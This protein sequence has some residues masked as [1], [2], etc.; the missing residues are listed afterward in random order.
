MLSYSYAEQ[1]IR[2][3]VALWRGCSA[4]LGGGVHSDGAPTGHPQQRSQP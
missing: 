1:G 3:P 4:G 2:Q